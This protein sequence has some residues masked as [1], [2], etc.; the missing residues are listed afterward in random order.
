[1]LNSQTI[2]KYNEV[3]SQVVSWCNDTKY[4]KPREMILQ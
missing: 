4:W 2:Q 3:Q 1:M